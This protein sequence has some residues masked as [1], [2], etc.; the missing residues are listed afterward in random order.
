MEQYAILST[1]SLDI[2][3]A[4]WNVHGK[5]RSWLFPG[6]KQDSHIVICTGNEYIKKQLKNLGWTYPIRS[7]T[8]RHSFATYLYEQG[9]DLL[10]I[11]KHLGHRSINST[12]IYVHLVR[13]SRGQVISPFD[14]Q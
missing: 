4:Y 9:N 12:T 3:T 13:M 7:H 2:L 1:R 10:S 14:K 5:P 6:Q 11:Q 8:F